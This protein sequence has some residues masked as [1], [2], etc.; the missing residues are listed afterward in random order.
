MSLVESID[1]PITTVVIVGYLVNIFGIQTAAKDAVG[2]AAKREFA[3]CQ[4]LRD[5]CCTAARYAIVLNRGFYFLLLPALTLFETFTIQAMSDRIAGRAVTTS[6][7]RTQLWNCVRVGAV[8]GLAVWLGLLIHS[9]LQGTGDV[10]SPPTAFSVISFLWLCPV[11][12]AGLDLGFYTFHR[13]CH[14]YPSL[15]RNVH[16]FHHVNTAKAHGRLMAY[17][18]YSLTMTETVCIILSYAVGLIFVVL[19]KGM[20]W[21]TLFELAFF[22]TYGH[23]VELTGHTALAITPKRYPPRILL[24][25]L[26]LDLR[27][28]DHTNHHLQPNSNFSKRMNLWDRLCGTYSPVVAQ[29]T[30]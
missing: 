4:L 24:E 19:A 2:I 20:Y 7:T 22:V 29:K 1:V 25:L 16:K 11:F 26:S 12:D 18:T 8:E 27:V 21:P 28:A 13:S 6:I 3:T 5:V 30:E 14:Q 10:N 15:Y 17:E 9:C 23:M